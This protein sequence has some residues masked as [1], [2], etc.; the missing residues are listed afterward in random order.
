MEAAS[1]RLLIIFSR[2]ANAPPLM[3]S[4]F[5]VSIWMKSPLGFLRPGSCARIKKCAECGEYI[6]PVDTKEARERKE[7]RHAKKSRSE[8][9]VPAP[10]LGNVD[11]VSL[12]DFEQRVLHPLARDVAADADV[13]PALANLVDLVDVYDAP[14]AAFDVLSALE[15]QLML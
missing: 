11:H 7:G 8:I 3:N 12:H 4:M 1:M 9:V 14:L 13:P 10:Y 6:A 2:P 5:V 15:V